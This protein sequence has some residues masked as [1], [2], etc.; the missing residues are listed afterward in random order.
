MRTVNE[1]VELLAKRYDGPTE[2]KDGFTYVP[3][4][5]V[6]RQLDRIFGPTNWSSEP[7]SFVYSPGGIYTS[8]VKVTARAMDEHGVVEFSRFGISSQAAQAT[9]AEREQGLTVTTNSKL[10][11]TAAD[12]S[13]SLALVK[14]T[15]Q[16]G[17]AFGL[18]LYNKS[19]ARGGSSS[20]RDYVS[21]Q[22]TT[23]G[24][25]SGLLERKAQ[26]PSKDGYIGN[27]SPAQ[28]KHANKKGWTND[29][30][31]RLTGAEVRTVMDGVFGKGPEVTPP[32]LKSIPAEASTTSRDDDSLGVD[33]VF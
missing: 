17:D 8:V 14:A 23:N 6:V 15:K 10:H 11:E 12:G 25:L 13:G 31:V 28:A 33:D 7:V 20:G 22:K 30:L 19:E 9:K 24:D 5:E 4:P 16:L 29:M 21:S 27:V 18:Y 3:W 26:Q 2:E 1:V 32:N